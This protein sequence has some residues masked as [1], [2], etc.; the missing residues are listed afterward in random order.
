MVMRYE[1]QM[2][3]SLKIDLVSEIK[4]IVPRTSYFVP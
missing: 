1:A 2:K 4:K 3:L